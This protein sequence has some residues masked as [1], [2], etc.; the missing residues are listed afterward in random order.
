MSNNISR[1]NS[2]RMTG[3]V[4]GLE[5]EDIVKRMLMS[6]QTRLDKAKQKRDFVNW[7]KDAY[8]SVI[9]SMNEFQSKF[10]DI[11]SPAGIVRA[12]SF[13][14]TTATVPAGMAQYFNATASSDALTSSVTVNSISKLATAQK[15]ESVGKISSDIA[16][17]ITDIDRLDDVSGKTLAVSFNGVTKNIVLDS[18]EYITI[19]AFSNK[20]FDYGDF[21][22]YINGELDKLFGSGKLKLSDTITAG[23]EFKFETV[24]ATGNTVQISG[25]NDVSVALGFVNNAANYINTEKTIG[26]LFGNSVAVGGKVKFSINGVEFIA[27]TTAKMKDVINEINKSPAGVNISYSTLSDK[28]T[29]TAKNTGSGENIILKDLALNGTD[30]S[31]LQ[32]V[33]KGTPTAIGH[34]TDG[35]DAELK[36]NG[37]TIFRSG[38]TFNIDGVTINLLKETPSS[39]VENNEAVAVK[40]D[41]AQIIDVIKNFVTEYNKL[42]ANLTGLLTEKREKTGGNFYMPLTDE[43]R[44]EMNEKDIAKWEE[45]GKKGLLAND[46]VISKILSSMRMAVAGTVETDHGK[47]SLASIGIKTVSFLDDSMGSAIGLFGEIDEDR[48]RH[49]I[50]NDPDAVMKLFTQQSPLPKNAAGDL[51]TQRYNTLGVGQKL[52]EIFFGAVNVTLNEKER[53]SLIMKVGTGGKN[54]IIDKESSFEKQLAEMEKTITKIQNRLYKEEEKYYKRFAAL[55]KAMAKLS[56]Q[57]AYLFSDMNRQNNY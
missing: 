8:R 51:K 15:I 42:L 56:S 24:Q 18:A 14:S 53:G 6:Q 9:T 23:G 10:L 21:K 47:I 46:P 38:N 25:A 48:L 57:S 5:T 13:K 55:E 2:I 37:T 39:F 11:L 17:Q 40:V 31:F 4:S 35:E 32:A 34:K 44:S 41:S 29:L 16:M 28:F 54:M 1:I 50:E 27:D 7:Q 45:Q 33:F 22:T 30:T 3:L 26:E 43:Q 12:G 49:A 19:D 36:V 52:S 20:I